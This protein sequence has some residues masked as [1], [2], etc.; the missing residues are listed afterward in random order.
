MSTQWTPMPGHGNELRRSLTAYGQPSVSLGIS[1]IPGMDG[2]DYV[3]VAVCSIQG[4]TVNFNARAMDVQQAKVIADALGKYARH[5]ARRYER[6]RAR[7]DLTRGSVAL[8]LD[9]LDGIDQEG[10]E[11]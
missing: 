5:T 2:L 9:D 10:G 8:K 7:R 6:K 4:H 3:A 1:R 11:A